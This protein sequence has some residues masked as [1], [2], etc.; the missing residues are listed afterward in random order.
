MSTGLRSAWQQRAPSS[1]LSEE[2]YEATQRR[3][4]E[5]IF[6]SN[7]ASGMYGYGGSS[8]LGLSNLAEVAG[9]DNLS[10]GLRSAS[11]D[12]LGTASRYATEHGE[13]DQVKDLGSFWN[14]VRANAGQG[15]G[16]MAPILTAA[17]LGVL[18]GVAAA[19]APMYGENIAT[20]EDD[21]SLQGLSAGQ[22][23][24]YAAPTAALQGGLNYLVPG[25]VV[26]NQARALAARAGTGAAGKAVGTVAATGLVEGATE[27]GEEALRQQMHSV[28]NPQRD[29]SGDTGELVQALYS[30]ALGGAPVGGAQAA[31]G[32]VQDKLADRTP[33]T[34]TGEQRMADRLA[35]AGGAAGRAVGAMEG[36]RAEAELD[37]IEAEA[38]ERGVPAGQVLAERMA[39]RQ[40]ARDTLTD[41]FTLDPA[42]T[43][44]QAQTAV[45]ENDAQRDEA[46]RVW[47][48]ETL[49]DNT[50]SP[51]EQD[52]ARE[53]QARSQAGANVG[54]LGSALVTSAEATAQ[55]AS[56]VL[57]TLL[58]RVGIKPAPKS[59]NEP[60]RRGSAMA[61]KGRRPRLDD[62][63][64]AYRIGQIYESVDQGSPMRA[65]SRA[66][67]L[68]LDPHLAR[69]AAGEG[70]PESRTILDQL[71]GSPE[72]SERV[73]EL[74]REGR[75]TGVAA[76][77]ES[78]AD[79][80][81]AREAI[82]DTGSDANITDNDEGFSSG[83]GELD[84]RANVEWNKT[85]AVKRDGR[86]YYDS[87]DPEQ[88]ERMERAS[89]AMREARSG[90][91]AADVRSVGMI[92]REVEAR[93]I[94]DNRD[95]VEALQ[96]AIT[97][98]YAREPLTQVP[99][100]HPN[101]E[102]MS[103][104]ARNAHRRAREQYLQELAR[105]V[106]YI[107]GRFKAVRAEYSETATGDLDFT[108]A[109]VKDVAVNYG[110]QGVLNPKASPE[111]GTLVFERTDVVNDFL[112][113]SGKLIGHMMHKVG[114]AKESTS[115]DSRPEELFNLLATAI[116]SLGQAEGFT[117]RFGYVESGTVT[118]I[119][120]GD[121][122]PDNFLVYRARGGQQA[123]T[124]LDVH[125][126]SVSERAFRTGQEGADSVSNIVAQI[127]ARLQD[128]D[129][130]PLPDELVARLNDLINRFSKAPRDVSVQDEIKAVYRENFGGV[131]S[132][133]EGAVGNRADVQSED[134]RFTDENNEPLERGLL[135]YGRV[136]DGRD[137][138]IQR[139]ERGMVSG[140]MAGYEL[141]GSARTVE[142]GQRRDQ[143]TRATPE[144]FEGVNDAVNWVLDNIKRGTPFF[145]NAVK[146]MSVERIEIL[147]NAF[148]KARSMAD[149]QLGRYDRE[150]AKVRERLDAVAMA[151]KAKYAPEVPSWE[152]YR[153]IPGRWKMKAN[154][155]SLDKGEPR[156]LFKPQWHEGFV[157]QMREIKAAFERGGRA[158]QEAGNRPLPLGRTPVVLRAVLHAAKGKVFRR[159]EFLVGS[160]STTHLKGLDKHAF[161]SHKDAVSFD[162]LLKLPD[163]LADPIAVFQSS[164]GSSDPNSFK[165]LIN[166]KSNGGRPV[167]VAIKPETKLNQAGGELANFQASII[168]VDW[169]DVERWNRD[170]LLRYYKEGSPLARVAGT[171]SQE[172]GAEARTR[173]GFDP[174]IGEKASPV[175][176]MSST[177]L[178]SLPESS[179]SA[180][181]P[182]ARTVRGEEVQAALEEVQ[183]LL[184]KDFPVEAA[185]EL[186]GP[187]G[188]Q[189]SG[190]H[191]PGLIRIAV[192]A[193][194]HVGVARHEALHQIFEWLR[195]NG[196]SQTVRLIENTAKNASI[197]N[198][199]KLLLKDHPGALKQLSDPEE[200]AAYL[201]QF[202]RAG[203]IKLGTQTEGFFKQI[204]DLLNRV[205]LAIRDH[206]FKDGKARESRAQ[207]A[208][209]E[210]VERI[211]DDINQEAFANADNRANVIEAIEQGAKAVNARRANEKIVNGKIRNFY[212]RSLAT[213]ASAFEDSQ[214]PFV[215]DLGKKLF[216]L[217]GDRSDR[218]SFI[219][220]Y[221]MHNDR[222]QVKIRDILFSIDKD[223]LPEVLRHLNERTERNQI[224][225]PEVREAVDKIDALMDE[226]FTFQTERGVQRFDPDK[227]EWVPINKIRDRYW[228]R[229]WSADYLLA[230]QNKF[231]DKMI[232]ALEAEYAKGGF[233]EIENKN[234][235]E[236]AKVIFH[237][238]VNGRGAED[239]SE[240]ETDLGISPFAAAVN[241]RKL[242]WIDDKEFAEFFSQD[243][244]ETLT[245]YATQTTK[246]AVYTRYFGKDGSELR[247]ALE[248][249]LAWEMVGEDRM[250]EVRAKL[251]EL[252]S[253]QSKRRAV[254]AKAGDEFSES[255]PTLVSAARQVLGAEADEAQAAAIKRLETVNKA[256]MAIEGTLGRE[257]DPTLRQG[258]SAVTTYQNFRLLPLALF[259]SMNDIVGLVNRGGSF[260]DAYQALARG[261]REIRLRWKDE[262]STD[263]L[264]KIA[265]RHGVVGANT[266]SGAMGHAYSS[267]FMHGKMRRLNDWLFKMNGLE[268]WNRAV[269]IQATGSAIAFIEDHAARLKADPKN[270]TSRRYMEELFGENFQLKNIVDADGKILE[271]N[272][273]VSAG[274]LS[275]VNGAVLRPNA[276]HRPIHASDIHYQMF[277]HLKQFAYSFHK[278]ILRRTWNEMQHGNYGPLTTLFVGYVPVT[279]AAD[280]VKEL[281]IVGDDDAWWTKQGGV[282]MLSHG[283]GRAAIGG[284]PQMWL[285]DT[286]GDPL[287]LFSDPGRFAS[288]LSNVAG[289]APDQLV[290]MLT[291]PVFDNKEFD[292]EFWGG[293]PGGVVWRRYV[294]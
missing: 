6:T 44:E 63:R 251:K 171:N 285:G 230:H 243:L 261:M 33:D 85:G 169:R 198:K 274:I 28:A 180:Q 105:R 249:A 256:V 181:T 19:T 231:M 67:V 220:N 73:L 138:V 237:T 23:S 59:R 202:W 121:A 103:V 131:F 42:A 30:G 112:T 219:E 111:N 136:G 9:A 133:G 161:A 275:W 49:A 58:E 215:Q 200:A 83:V 72:A 51:L 139:D 156:K 199:L 4:N 284:V 38:A 263:E 228:T 218:Q 143:P 93:G 165:V 207:R 8:L 141:T 37:R 99:E 167:V 66:E 140:P 294:D 271:G 102:N 57:A 240:T 145:M 152:L 147:A 278:V 110:R 47:A 74:Y 97:N 125:N 188:E 195:A 100:R 5:N 20:L 252:T 153:S 184:G 176:V 286:V 241:Q 191:V 174:S 227:K 92:E 205:Q 108:E 12:L 129:A 77:D 192:G 68:D 245:N 98:E 225:I 142:G 158:A 210:L 185:K 247:G 196:G 60:H 54:E 17:P 265:E 234:A 183:R 292:R 277:Y 287:T 206:V 40:A 282:E 3:G 117:G 7:L 115:Q 70:T 96:L 204:L 236:H 269:R 29:T 163:L 82:D 16:S 116:T 148:S 14:S 242:G 291:V 182:G 209:E 71:T 55:R 276:S 194:D 232:A 238:L 208:R 283:V 50:T 64:T 24:L 190:E 281:L 39:R 267:Q 270:E 94:A 186:L 127:E 10:R 35:D 65:L 81:E 90:S 11:S 122:L 235:R 224:A 1:D 62:P 280:L 172:S 2:L 151:L 69:F 43:A 260:K 214:N 95:A 212:E 222:F 15:L 75:S 211:F 157:R 170:G 41:S 86:S 254:A 253:D 101:H 268:A 126:A 264:A 144:R 272:E 229:V 160:G 168:P 128:E 255:K 246:R 130:A 262:Y 213:A 21:E 216:R 266:Y 179:W 120:D 164:E 201:F 162:T 114:R 290:D 293:L 13:L 34:R 135:A 84:V 259:A 217:E 150:V 25:G 166:A 124:A 118:W 78:A 26:A 36:R 88:A 18:P 31:A 197:Q 193:Q 189:W 258:I 273:R 132:A 53:I 250:G 223:F 137:A 279:L 91:A 46:A 175:K 104:P 61:V 87:R 45:A 154:A 80:A 109:D 106:R 173:E 248:E 221:T 203:Q 226:L 52:A 146:S 134:T 187:D 178:A 257:I 288:R 149:A 48:D 119:E 27:A 22:K 233:P 89:T 56:G 239:S 79:A 76:L 123:I 155:Q 289:P 159:S 32:Y 244:V 177:E 113:S 107:N